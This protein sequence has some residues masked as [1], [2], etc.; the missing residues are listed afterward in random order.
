MKTRYP[1]PRPHPAPGIKYA[2]QVLI[3][4]AILVAAWVMII[5]S[6]AVFTPQ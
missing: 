4:G 1:K 2:A 6:W 5:L 3:A